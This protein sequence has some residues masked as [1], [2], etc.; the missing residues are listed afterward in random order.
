M[1]QVKCK[2]KQYFLTSMAIIYILIL[3]MSIRGIINI[4]REKFESRI[5]FP[6]LIKILILEILM[7][8]S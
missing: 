4:P 1:L 5:R 7:I 8:C 3:I 2:F 6:V